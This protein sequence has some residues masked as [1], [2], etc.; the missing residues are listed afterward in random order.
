MM[1]RAFIVDDEPP[2][3]ARL[4]Q[5]LQEVGGIVVVGE[6]GDAVD[7]R[8]AIPDCR[9]DVVFLDVEMP[10]E[11][12]TSLAGSL[13]EPRP[14]VV[15]ATAFD[16]YALE[17]FGVDATDYLVKPI[18][19][20][21]LA[22]TLA[23]LRERVARRSELERDVRDASAVQALLF[24]RTLPNADGYDTAA[25]TLPARGVGGDFFVGQEVDAGRVI[26]ALGDVAGKGVPA[27]LVAS[28]LQARLEAVA[29][30]GGEH[31]VDVVAGVNRVLCER[32]DTSRFATLAYLQLDPRAH[33]LTIVNAGHLP[34][35][36]ISQNGSTSRIETTAPALGILPEPRIEPREV[37]L[38][39]GDLVLL[40]SDGVTEAFDALDVEYGDGRLEA[41]VAAHI[42]R[43]ARAICQAVVDDV[44][45]HAVGGVAGDDV[46]V[47]VIRRLGPA[48]GGASA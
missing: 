26:Y 36:V 18:T 7:A 4:K 14:Y 42:D 23:R 30:H 38:A 43:P 19:R 31:A 34:V 46:S 3:R 45:R 29:A 48:G 17:A 32:S 2:A 16:R 27:G 1:L 35:L 8:A 37:T 13:P 39:P 22:A 33:R 28:S 44:R 9:P 20:A 15:F 10:Q 21:R 5:L 41:L 12:G 40:Y 11:S 6:A 25:L 47:L 24:P